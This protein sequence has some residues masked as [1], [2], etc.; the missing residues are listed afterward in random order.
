MAEHVLFL[1]TGQNTLFRSVLSIPPLPPGKCLESDE[2]LRAWLEKATVDVESTN[3]A[4][5]GYSAGN[6]NGAR[7]DDKDKPRVLFNDQ[8]VYLGLALF[9]PEIQEWGLAGVPGEMKTVKRSE[10]N[11][12][13]DMKE[14]A[15]AGWFLADGDNGT[16]DMTAH[17]GFFI[18]AAPDYDVYTVQ[19]VQ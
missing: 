9:L 6:K 13:D 4:M 14:K 11:V 1:G 10:S 18:G 12:E 2:D 3:E 19:K 15:L 7:P 16:E 8:G 5:F 17:G